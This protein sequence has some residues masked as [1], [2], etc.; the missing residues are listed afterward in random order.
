MKTIPDWAL[1]LNC[2]IT[3]CDLKGKI[4]YMNEKAQKTFSKWG[5]EN[6]IGQ[7]LFSCHKQSS[8]EKII[9]LMA[10][11]ETNVYTIEKGG[12]KKLIYQTP[13][14]AEEKIAGMTEISLEIPTEMQHFV[15]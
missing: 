8:A 6:L 2:A 1:G 12:V 9:H 13:W 7:N 3:V 5:G 15:R 4:L 11:N 10:N 14:Y